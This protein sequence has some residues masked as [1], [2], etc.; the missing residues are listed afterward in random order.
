MVRAKRF[1]GTEAIF[2]EGSEAQE[3]GAKKLL[4]N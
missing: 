1:M 3:M 2:G 4:I